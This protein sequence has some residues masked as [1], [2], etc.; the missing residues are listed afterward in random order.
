MGD[1]PGLRGG[2]GLLHGTVCLMRTKQRES[3]QTH[4]KDQQGGGQDGHDPDVTTSKGIVTTQ[5]Q[6]EASPAGL[7]PETPVSSQAAFPLRGEGKEAALLLFGSLTGLCAVQV[8][9]CVSRLERVFFIFL[10]AST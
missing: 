8:S 6:A 2:S 4:S 9:I 7:L 10:R 3:G 5:R 1:F